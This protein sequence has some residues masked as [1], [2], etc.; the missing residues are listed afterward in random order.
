[1]PSKI[2]KR[3]ESSYLLTVSAGYDAQGR[4]ITHTKTITAS[5]I[6]EAK[7]LYS[8]FVAEIE[9]GQIARSGK[10]TLDD[11]FDYWLQNYAEGRHEPK[12]IT[13]NKGYFK[14]ISQ[15][16]GHKRID[17]IEPKHLLQFY[18]N[19]TEPIKVI[20]K[21]QTDPEKPAAPEYLSPNTIRKYHVLLHT[22]FEKATQWQ[23]IAY[24]PAEKV[25]S[26]K[27]E[28]HQKVIYDED[29]TGKFLLLLADVP[30][31]YRAMV[32]I[33]L[34]SGIR[35]GEL[36]GLTWRHIDTDAGTIRVEQAS[37]YLPEKGIFTKD[38]K[39]EGSKRIV[40]IPAS[41][42]ALLKQYKA[43][44]IA[45]RLK[46]GKKS[47]GGKWEGTEDAEDDFIF[48]AWN[49]KPA[50]PDSMNNW[51]RKFINKNGLPPITPHSFRHMAATYLITSGTD[52]RTVAG[53]LGHSSSTTTQVVY[54]HLL[55][56]AEKETAEKMESFLQQATD[57]AKQAQ[58][59]QA[60]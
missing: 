2:K 58:K 9:K 44:Q 60:R 45:R 31:R 10:M 15:A 52:L 36:F 5:G 22:L 34:S 47:T 7:K 49:G 56:S 57:K 23:F 8:L 6:N 38:P 55:K 40:S 17:K 33:S 11:F 54:S 25:E 21:K 3:G 14:R 4:Q 29:T 20:K 46:L 43:E 24:N 51:L 1:M 41:T 37:Q 12:T 50:H 28:H 53:K 59:K 42:C 30:L 19:L 32:L 39:N 18:K 13:Y 26:P 16:L 35:R 27:T 48:T